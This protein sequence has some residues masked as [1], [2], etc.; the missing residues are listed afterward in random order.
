MGI[1]G[2]S[3]FPKFWVASMAIILTMAA[4]MISSCAAPDKQ[5][6]DPDRNK[7]AVALFLIRS[8]Y[9]RWAAACGH[10][11]GKKGAT[12][13]VAVANCTIDHQNSGLA[14]DEI[15]AKRLSAGAS[16]ANR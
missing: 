15:V 7:A 12:R 8:G 13:E 9:D 4:V 1:P 6:E 5:A 11:W 2:C 14:H 16:V 3:K 10:E